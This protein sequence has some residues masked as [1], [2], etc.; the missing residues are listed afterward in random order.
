MY[1]YKGALLG[2][3]KS[4]EL[5]YPSI[6]VEIPKKF[7]I[8]N[9]SITRELTCVRTLGSFGNYTTKIKDKTTGI[10]IEIKPHQ[11]LFS[12]ENSVQSFSVKLTVDRKRYGGDLFVKHLV[13][14]KEY[15][16]VTT[17]KSYIYWLFFS[18][19]HKKKTPL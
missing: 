17:Q 16:K 8:Y 14:K 5:N 18:D 15:H 10:D 19:I 7:K 4:Y 3:I 9:C 11:L 6:M 12:P 1:N 2:K 13:W